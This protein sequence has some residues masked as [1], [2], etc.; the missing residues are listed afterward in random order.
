[1]DLQ[2]AVLNVCQCIDVNILTIGQVFLDTQYVCPN[3]KLEINIEKQSKII[4]YYC[5]TVLSLE[6]ID[7]IASKMKIST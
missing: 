7:R 1:M 5:N 2:R 4:Q 6:T 3:Y